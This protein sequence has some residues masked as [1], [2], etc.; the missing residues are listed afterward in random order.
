MKLLLKPEEAA[1]ALGVGRSKL[2]ALLAAGQIPCIRV[3]G[4]ARVPADALRQ[5]IA[6]H[7]I[8]DGRAGETCSERSNEE[9]P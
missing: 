9:S 8:P 6:D 1:E 4:M 7:T 5:W 3:G 2:Y